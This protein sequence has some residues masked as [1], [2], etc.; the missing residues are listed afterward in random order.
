M[1]FPCHA[2][3]VPSHA[4]RLVTGSVR[5]VSLFAAA[6]QQMRASGWSPGCVRQLETLVVGAPLLRRSTRRARG[7]RATRVWPI[8]RCVLR[9]R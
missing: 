8:P 5:F 7:W 4:C 1:D 6:A 3:H 2:A 9:E